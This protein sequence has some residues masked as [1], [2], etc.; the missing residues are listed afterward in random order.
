MVGSHFLQVFGEGCEG[1][2]GVP[3]E[4]LSGEKIGGEVVHEAVGSGAMVPG[5][6]GLDRGIDARVGLAE[7]EEVGEETVL[8]D[9]HVVVRADIVPVEF[10]VVA[11]QEEAIAVVMPLAQQGKAV[12]RYAAVHSIPSINEVLRRGARAGIAQE[13]ANER[14]GRDE[15]A[16]E[17]FHKA[18]G[19]ALAVGGK[20][21]EAV[22]LL[23]TEQVAET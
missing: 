17:L 2:V 15:S 1:G 9:G 7:V 21:Q 3:A 14:V 18:V 10:V 20:T 13:G 22:H 12:G 5:E 6:V 23:L 11:Q 8:E 19:S 16:L 4:G